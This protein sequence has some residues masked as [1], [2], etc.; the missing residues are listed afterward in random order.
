MKNCK[1][2]FTILCLL[3]VVAGACAQTEST[4]VEP[5]TTTPTTGTYVY[6]FTITL[7]SK[8][9]ASTKIACVGQVQITSDTALTGGVIATG[10]SLATI[11]GSAATCSVSISYAWNLGSP[12]SDK[13]SRIIQIAA[14]PQSVLGTAPY[15]GTQIH[16]GNIAVPANGSTTTENVSVTL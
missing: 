13:F 1:L 5:Q 16:L 3:A 6:N 15:H 14:P 4:S 12:A 9:P 2:L 10:T 11:S 8:I 7:L